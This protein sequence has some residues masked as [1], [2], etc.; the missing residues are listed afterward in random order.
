MQ[1]MTTGPAKLHS[2]PVSS[3][4]QQLTDNMTLNI[5]YFILLIAWRVI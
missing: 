5:L 4:I 2:R 1:T 3:E